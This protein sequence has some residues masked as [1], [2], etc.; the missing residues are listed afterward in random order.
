LPD[1]ELHGGAGCGL[2]DTIFLVWNLYD[3]V[4]QYRFRLSFFF[5]SFSF[6]SNIVIEQEVVPMLP[7]RLLCCI[8]EKD[9][10]LVCLVLKLMSR[11]IAIHGCKQVSTSAQQCR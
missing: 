1:V 2:I 11:L 9:V 8:G 4:S 6:V 5:C 10:K 7:D 3:F